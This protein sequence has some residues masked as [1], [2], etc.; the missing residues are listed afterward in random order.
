[1]AP[2][3]QAELTVVWLVATKKGPGSQQTR[4]AID[5]SLFGRHNSE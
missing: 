1:M 3:A 4:A 2:R 5:I